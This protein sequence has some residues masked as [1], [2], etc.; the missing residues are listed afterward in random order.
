MNV[1]Q[2]PNRDLTISVK[3]VPYDNFIVWWTLH[4]G[5]C[6]WSGDQF[7]IICH[8]ICDWGIGFL[9]SHPVNMHIVF[10]FF[11]WRL[12]Y[13]WLQIHMWQFFP[14]PS[15]LL[16]CRLGTY[17]MSCL[18]SA[19]TRLNTAT[20]RQNARHFADDIFK[21]IFLNENVWISIIISLKFV[22]R[23][24]INNIQALVRGD[25]PLS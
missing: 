5:T 3:A 23:G 18:L 20:P 15:W 12:T 16:H 7:R 17:R 2:C 14:C 8:I 21:C 22:P 6:I 11:L 25:K 13:S 19:S 9:D 4:N 1:D 24:Q 10:F